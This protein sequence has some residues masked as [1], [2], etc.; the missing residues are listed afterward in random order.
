MDTANC[1]TPWYACQGQGEIK[2]WFVC[3]CC[4][5]IKAEIRDAA[6]VSYLLNKARTNGSFVRGKLVACYVLLVD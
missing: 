3:P 4:G 6:F 1:K 5:L 2:G